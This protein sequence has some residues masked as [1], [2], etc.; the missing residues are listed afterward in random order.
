MDYV[1]IRC[2]FQHR[3][4]AIAI[5]TRYKSRKFSNQE[6]AIQESK[7]PFSFDKNAEIAT[8][9]DHIVDL[10]SHKECYNSEEICKDPD[11]Q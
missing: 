5:C 10:T 3:V 9:T 11:K 6:N 4:P 2:S 1:L 8:V 7:T